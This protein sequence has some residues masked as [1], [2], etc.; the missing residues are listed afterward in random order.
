MQNLEADNL[1]ERMR[2]AVSVAWLI[3]SPTVKGGLILVNKEASMQLQYAY[4]LQQLA[5][6]II[7]HQDEAIRV[8]FEAGASVD[9]LSREI[10]FL[11]TGEG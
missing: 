1:P 11:F 8:E 2:A 5:L 9:G 4:I 10:D 3:F 7:F 6:L